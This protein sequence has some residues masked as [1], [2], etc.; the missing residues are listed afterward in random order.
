MLPMQVN[1]IKE[2]GY[3]GHPNM[4]RVRASQKC[5][6]NVEAIY[7]PGRVVLIGVHHDAPRFWVGLR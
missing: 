5:E 6:T 2:N 7:T 3:Y 4:A 1:F